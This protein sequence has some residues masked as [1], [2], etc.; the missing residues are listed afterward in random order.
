MA[1]RYSESEKRSLITSYLAS[2]QSCAAYSRVCGVSAITIKSW[3]HQ[4]SENTPTGFV[5]ISEPF[6]ISE[7]GFRVRV[8]TDFMGL[9]PGEVFVVRGVDSTV[10]AVLRF[11]V[12]LVFRNR[13]A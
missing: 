4:Y 6:G 3:Q 8:G 7:S 11:C 1:K 9:S 5:A 13:A 2:G 12:E 10:R